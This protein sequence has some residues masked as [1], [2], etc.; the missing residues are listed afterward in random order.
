MLTGY[1]KFGHMC[2]NYHP[3]LEES[4][5]GMPIMLPEQPRRRT[6]RG[7]SK[8]LLSGSIGN[9]FSDG[10]ESSRQ[11]GNGRPRLALQ[12]VDSINDQLTGRQSPTP[13]T[14][15][16]PISP[17][18]PLSPS[19][20][21]IRKVN[22]ILNRLTE[23][24]FE[25]CIESLY[26]LLTVEGV[27]LQRVLPLVF[28]KAIAESLLCPLYCHL[29]HRLYLFVEPEQQPVLRSQLVQLI[30]RML[31]GIE[32][33]MAQVTNEEQKIKISAKRVGN[34]QF[35]GEA[36]HEEL[37]DADDIG[38]ILNAL[39]EAIRQNKEAAFHVELACRLLSTCGA[40]LEQTIPV[41][42]ADFVNQLR[43]ESENHEKRVQVLVMNLVELKAANWVP[44]ERQINPASPMSPEP[45]P[46]AAIP[47]PELLHSPPTN[48][49]W[50]FSSLV[51]VHI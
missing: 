10:A 7:S 19:D 14:P 41:V 6:P 48:S 1:C 42:V 5:L 45:S 24:K 36:F 39:A 9:A 37:I 4:L 34:M 29:I 17:L 11:S 26:E 44:R 12:M 3:P 47:W 28:A 15:T 50:Q 32:D 51:P 49:T 20:R 43:A 38:Q 21:G 30:Y 35:A 33:L 31:L 8:S 2:R 13:V 27:S 16:T 22:G 18:S 40:A 25:A 46:L 23:A